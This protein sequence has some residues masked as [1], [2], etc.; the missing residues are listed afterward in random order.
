MSQQPPEPEA[1][2]QQPSAPS[3]PT[4]GQPAPQPPVTPPG[5]TPPTAWSPE[6]PPQWGPPAGPPPPGWGQP[7]GPPPPGWGQPGW[8]QPAGAQP[9]GWGPAWQAAQAPKPGIV[10]LRPIGVGELLDGA[11]QLI[12]SNPRTVLGLAA[13]ISAVSAVIQTIGLAS[14]FAV[15]DLDATSTPVDPDPTAELLELGTLTAAQLLPAIVAAFL[16]SLA[17][18]LFIVLVGAAVLGRRLDAGQ[19][20]TLLRPRLLALLGLTLLLG[21]GFTAF[22]GIVVGVIVLLALALGGWAAIPGLLLAL[23]AIVASVYVYV[24]LAVAPPALVMEGRSPFEALGR[25]WSLIRGSWW[26]V[27]GILL[28]ASVITQVLAG[29]VTVPI[30]VISSVGA[31]LLGADAAD[32]TTPMVIATGIATLVSGIIIMP[33][34][35]AVTGL[36]YTDLRIRREALDIELVSAGVDPSADPLAPYKRPV[37]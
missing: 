19:T 12:R 37:G 32:A 7:A 23:A 5:W 26:R 35:A 21:V 18:G 11:L 2:G 15:I 10:P 13:V 28:L 17:S 34:S 36:L 20:W 14:A 16:Q 29:I 22:A 30:T 27:A 24:R 31:A 25:S 9:P 6:Q 3:Q 8:G 33:F 1:E 4:W